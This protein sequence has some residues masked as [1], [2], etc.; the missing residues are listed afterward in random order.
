MCEGKRAA[1]AIFAD[2]E[3]DDEMK[4][5]EVSILVD[6]LGILEGQ[7][8]DMEAQRCS[9]GVSVTFGKKGHPDS[10]NK[11]WDYAC[12]YWF[13]D[14]QGIHLDVSC[15]MK[16]WLAMEALAA[17][18]NLEVTETWEGFSNLELNNHAAQRMLSE[19][20]GPEATIMAINK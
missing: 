10:P 12:L 4:G 15:P 6:M 3:E 11:H 18:N 7:Y 5:T 17:R 2:I 13:N 8:D 9:H 20:R 14:D 1:D 19:L 16:T